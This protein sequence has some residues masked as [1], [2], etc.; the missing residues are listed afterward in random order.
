MWVQI[1]SAPNGRRHTEPTQPWLCTLPPQLSEGPGTIL[2]PAVPTEQPCMCALCAP[3][4]AGGN[5]AVP[6]TPSTAL[7]PSALLGRLLGA[8]CKLC[9]PHCLVLSRVN[10]W[11]YKNIRLIKYVSQAGNC[12]LFWSSLHNGTV[13]G[14]SV[15]SLEIFS[16]VLGDCL[17][18]PVL[19][20]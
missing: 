13:V 12:C 2:V 6:I 16:D 10:P 15:A 14:A 3:A 9:R 1:P 8:L 18:W 4:V 7:P 5:Q 17:S 20:F 19:V 11:S